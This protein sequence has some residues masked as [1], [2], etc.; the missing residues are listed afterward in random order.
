MTAEER[1]ANAR[2]EMADVL[3]KKYGPDWQNKM[4]TEFVTEEML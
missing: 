4:R 2:A 1:T 3:G